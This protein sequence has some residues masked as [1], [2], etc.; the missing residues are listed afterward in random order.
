MLY[1]VDPDKRRKLY[2]ETI[3]TGQIIQEST[4]QAFLRMQLYVLRLP[5]SADADRFYSHQAGC[6]IETPQDKKKREQKMAARAAGREEEV[7]FEG[8]DEEMLQTA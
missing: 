5:I 1:A 2:R 7:Y 6:L 8:S 4:R 3:E